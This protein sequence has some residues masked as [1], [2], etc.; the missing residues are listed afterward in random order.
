[1]L[2]FE[3]KTYARNDVDACT[4]GGFIIEGR[5][6]PT[7]SQAIRACRELFDMNYQEAKNFCDRL[8]IAYRQKAAQENQKVK[9]V[10]Y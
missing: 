3:R 7:Q 4:N 2:S 1:M 9:A 6:Y 10:L 5:F 8:V